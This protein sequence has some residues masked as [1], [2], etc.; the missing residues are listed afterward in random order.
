MDQQR[1]DT[2]HSPF[3]ALVMI[4]VE[5]RQRP[6]SLF[7]MR[8]QVRQREILVHHWLLPVRIVQQA[9]LLR[10]SRLPG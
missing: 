8:G 7:D 3:V 6:D 2:G 1:R 4:G 9:E 5:L 10:S